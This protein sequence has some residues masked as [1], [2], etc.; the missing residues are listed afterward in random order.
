MRVEEVEVRD[1]ADAERLRF[2]GSPTI[3]VDGAD[4]EP[5]AGTRTDFA[6]SCRLYEGSGVPPRELLEAALAGSSTS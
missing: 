6:L 4:I 3:R 1:E 2:I 5:D